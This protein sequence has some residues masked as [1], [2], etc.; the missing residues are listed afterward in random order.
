MSIMNMKNMKKHS[1]KTET[2][3]T[4]TVMVN[5]VETQIPTT[6]HVVQNL[7]SGRDVVQAK[8]TPVC[9]DVSSETYWSM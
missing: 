6:H 8:N 9:C 7:M 4:Y 3:K 5:G 2:A 1:S